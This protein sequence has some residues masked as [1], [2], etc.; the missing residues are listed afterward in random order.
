MIY[1]L[2]TKILNKKKTVALQNVFFFLVLYI[3]IFLN[4]RGLFKQKMEEKIKNPSN[5]IWTYAIFKT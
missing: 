4:T 5:K 2:N 3:S 1:K